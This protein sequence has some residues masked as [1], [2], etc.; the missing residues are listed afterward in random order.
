MSNSFYNKGEPSQVNNN[1]Q[2]PSLAQNVNQF[3]EHDKSKSNLSNLVN[4]MS[5]ANNNSLEEIIIESNDN[6]F[7]EFNNQS[8]FLEK[9]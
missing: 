1:M 3:L 7:D 9:N 4:K 5:L 8:G 2:A 6:S